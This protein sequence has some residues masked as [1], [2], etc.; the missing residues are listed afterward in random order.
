MVLELKRQKKE[1]YEFI[2]IHRS[3]HPSTLHLDYISLGSLC[4]V[5]LRRI[6]QLISPNKELMP[7]PRDTG[8]SGGEEGENDPLHPSSLERSVA[9]LSGEVHPTRGVYWAFWI[10]GAGV[11]LAW[12]G[13]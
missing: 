12:N 8:Y 9:S 6:K 2:S 3:N 1:V 7:L 10:L 4:R 5:M 11:L 13:E